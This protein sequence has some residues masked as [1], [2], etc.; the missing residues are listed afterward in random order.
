M[1]FDYSYIMAATA[2]RVP[3]VYIENRRVVGLDP[4]DPIT[5]NYDAPVGT[6][7][8]GSGIRPGVGKWHLGLGFL[9]RVRPSRFEFRQLVEVMVV[10][11]EIE[12]VELR[13]REHS[14]GCIAS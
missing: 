5:V 13:T 6:W 8:T 12:P 7:P 3:T 4:A 14:A 9:R 1:G 2:D 11:R 10:M